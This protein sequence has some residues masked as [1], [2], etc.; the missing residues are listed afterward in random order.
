MISLN[1]K[2]ETVVSTNSFFYSYVDSYQYLVCCG[3]YQDVEYCFK[4]NTKAGCA[5]C[6]TDTTSPCECEACEG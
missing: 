5:F 3:E 2:G 6:E 4:S 1:N